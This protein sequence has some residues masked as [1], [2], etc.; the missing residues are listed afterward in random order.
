MTNAVENLN[1]PRP[2][3]V[4]LVSTDPLRV[5]GFQAIFENHGRVE[6]VTATVPVLLRDTSMH[7]V[8]L[9]MATDDTLFN[10]LETFKGFRPDMRLIVMSHAPQNEQIRR[11]ISAG[12]KG[13]LPDSASEAD[14]AMAIETVADGSIWAPRRVLASMIGDVSARPATTQIK[15][16]IE[17]T[18]RER[19]V[20]ERL[21]NGATNRQ[22]G[23]ELEIEERTVK[24]HIAKLMRKVGVNNRTALTMQAISQQLISASS[25]SQPRRSMQKS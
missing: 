24:A 3:R 21:V 19:D 8:L 9:C 25:T 16:N 1:A 7:L 2:F 12:A 20:L 4:G 11:M 10:L 15:G 5:V 18:A 17:L 23:E 14:I 6:M 22:I 13:I